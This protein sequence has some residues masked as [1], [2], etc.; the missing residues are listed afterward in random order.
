[1]SLPG[2]A[3]Q[4]PAPAAPGPHLQLVPGNLRGF[5]GYLKANNEFVQVHNWP[6]TLPSSSISILTNAQ[7]YDAENLPFMLHQLEQKRRPNRPVALGNLVVD[8]Y[9]LLGRSGAPLRFYDA[10][11]LGHIFWE[12]QAWE[13]AT[14]LGLGFRTKELVEHT[15]PND[16]TDEKQKHRFTSAEHRWRKEF[17]GLKADGFNANKVTTTE[18]AVITGRTAAQILFNTRWIPNLLDWTMTQPLEDGETPNPRST[19]FLLPY[20]QDPS[21]RVVRIWV[22]LDPSIPVPTVDDLPRMIHKAGGVWNGW[23]PQLARP[24]PQPAVLSAMGAQLRYPS[25]TTQPMFQAF[26]VR[27]P[28]PPQATAN[29]AH[30]QAHPIQT[31]LMMPQAAQTGHLPALMAESERGLD[32]LAHTQ[33]SPNVAHQPAFTITDDYGYE[34]ATPTPTTQITSP[35]VQPNYMVFYDNDGHVLPAVGQP[36]TSFYGQQHA[37]SSQH[38]A[39]D[40]GPSLD[41]TSRYQAAEYLSGDQPVYV[42]EVDGE[43]VE[44]HTGLSPV[45][46]YARSWWL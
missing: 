8:G 1:M 32:S 37:D 5:S 23:N 30:F 44:I 21:P 2:A 17:G 6:T 43:Y 7:T 29:P 24:A 42:A 26:A 13:I 9:F 46:D 10:H 4:Q 36:H 28:L 31:S 15:L 18:R 45:D 38:Q 14:L 19:P 39:A 22:D 3:L 33:Q 34:D 20:P 12:P 41:Q 11:P 16:I 35:H 40:T 25:V 27:R